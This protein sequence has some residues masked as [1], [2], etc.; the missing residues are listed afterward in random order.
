[1]AKHNIESSA[2]HWQDLKQDLLAM[3]DALDK[4]I[5]DV[6]PFAKLY[7]K[8]ANAL[9][10]ATAAEGLS[11]MR[12]RCAVKALSLATKKSELLGFLGEH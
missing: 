7:E 5:V 8:S 6:V 4:D 3:V 9:L 12:F 1:V 11:S 10:H 2:P